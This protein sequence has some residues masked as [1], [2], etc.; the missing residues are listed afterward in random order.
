MAERN[1]VLPESKTP[2]DGSV[3]AQIQN[4][5]L[6]DYE[7]VM[8][9]AQNA[10]REWRIFPRPQGGNCASNWNSVR[11]ARRLGKMISW[12]M[13]RFTRKAWR[14]QGKDRICDFAVGL[15]RQLYGFT[16]HRSDQSIACMINT[17]RLGLWHHNGF[18]LSGCSLVMELHD[19]SCLRRRVNLETKSENPALFNCP[20]TNT[21]QGMHEK[22]SRK[23]L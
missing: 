10:F 13:G 22:V 5:S 1:R 4:A 20:A 8:A 2:V 6:K 12:E 7:K 23:G 3:I 18:Q 9:G 11:E 15:S 14:S 16:M 17:I 19:C 21:R